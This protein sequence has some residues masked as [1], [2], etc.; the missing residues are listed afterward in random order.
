MVKINFCPFLEAQVRGVLI[1]G[2]LRDYTNLVLWKFI[3]NLIDY[4]CFTTASPTSYS[5]NKHPLYFST[6]IENLWVLKI[7][8]LRSEEHTSELQSRENLVCRLLLEKKE[9]KKK[10]IN[11]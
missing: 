11:N 3:D 1:I 7:G 10:K 2:I 5:Y 8:N 6:K 4:C 9:N